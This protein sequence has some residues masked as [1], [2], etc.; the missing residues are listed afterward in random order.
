[1]DSSISQ[2]LNSDSYHSRM[3]ASRVHSIIRSKSLPIGY[4]LV[5]DL[6]KSRG[7]R[8]YDSITG[9]KWIDMF[10]FYGSCPIGH[11]HP[12]MK[13]FAQEL[14][15]VAIHNPANSNV[16]TE[17][18]A[19]FV[20]EFSK[21][22]P[23]KFDKMFFIG[24]GALA[25]E[26]AIKAA[27]DWKVRS[28]ELAGFGTRINELKVIHFEDAFHG[29]S[30]YTMSMTNT[31]YWKTAYYPKFEWP[32]ITFPR[33]TYPDINA[34]EKDAVRQITRAIENN[35]NQIAAILVEPIQG[36]GGDNHM[37]PQFW[38]SLRQIANDNQVMLI[39]DEVQCGMGITGRP[40]AWQWLGQEPDM[41]VFGKKSQVCGFAANN[42]LDSVKDHV[43]QKPSR[44]NSTWGG[45]LVDMMR[46]R[47]YM[48]IIE[49][50]DLLTNTLE[51]GHYTL[52]RLKELCN[53]HPILTSNPRGRGLMI[54]FDLVNTEARDR[55][56]DLMYKRGVI[57]IT[58]GTR[59]IRIRPMLDV[60][61]GTMN[62]VISAM[63]KC[64]KDL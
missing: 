20:Q 59:T 16:Y 14:G 61:R 51:I 2:N 10:G 53:R 42:R 62:R 15:Q 33:T 22:F 64:L 44:M 43:F 19:R 47:K 18:Y 12:A 32:R 39:A 30:G 56:K 38:E 49:D 21:W 63:D 23:A 27:F 40:W 50:E 29:R 55:F 46:S 13:R 60:T 48:E 31:D 54:A 3:L 58:S 37:R 28:N 11:N 9:R 52:T 1:M 17:E 36:E 4:D 41:I 57:V 7:S 24:G 5:F 45:N 25:V 34:S 6:N 8:I 35:P 26:N